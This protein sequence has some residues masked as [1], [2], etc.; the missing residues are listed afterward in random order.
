MVEKNSENSSEVG[1]ISVQ[2]YSLGEDNI[3]EDKNFRTSILTSQE[4]IFVQT[5]NVPIPYVYS[6]CGEKYKI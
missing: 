2:Q 4:L 3:G 5:K 1:I 6:V